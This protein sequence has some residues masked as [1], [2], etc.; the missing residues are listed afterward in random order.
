MHRWVR[1]VE[2]DHPS[3]VGS[4]FSERVMATRGNR[5]SSEEGNVVHLCTLHITHSTTGDAEAGLGLNSIPA[6]PNHT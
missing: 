3:A 5:G 1:R 6:I 2:S 4:R